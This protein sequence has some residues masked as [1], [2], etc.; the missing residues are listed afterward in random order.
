MCLKEKIIPWFV[1]LGEEKDPDD[2]INKH[3]IV[4]FEKALKSAKP[5]LD[6]ILE[7]LIP[8]KIPEVSDHKLKILQ[9]AFEVLGP[10]EMSLNATER[11]VPF[12]QRL[13]LRSGAEQV[14]ENYKSFLS[15]KGGTAP[16][17]IVVR[18]SPPPSDQVKA[19]K[20][21][22]ESLTRGEKVFLKAILE[23]PMS[24]D[25]NAVSKILDLIPSSEVKEYVLKL[26]NLIYEVDEGEYSELAQTIINQGNYP[27]SLRE[28]VSAILYGL[29][30]GDSWNRDE[31][32]FTKLLSDIETELLLD[33]KLR[34]KK[35]LKSLFA[36]CEN[37]Q[38]RIV[39][40][41]QIID[42]EKDIA[43]TKSNKYKNH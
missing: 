43:L 3:G 21:K 15:Q 31:T 23:N 14:L 2:F 20:E 27:L 13:G 7:E 38:E 39:I 41:G 30:P 1:D 4:G 34:R 5:Y 36:A 40:L 22:S 28:S 8:E 17:N 11:I 25:H 26:R 37:E 29:Q 42:I 32:F 10:L 12:S 35:E 6:L 9:Q 24:L 19:P 16:T 33:Q 18:P